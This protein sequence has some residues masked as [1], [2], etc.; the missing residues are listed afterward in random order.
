ML[1]EKTYLHRFTVKAVAKGH[2][3][4]DNDLPVIESYR[5]L[6]LTPAVAVNRHYS[7]L[8][9]LSIA[10]R[11]RLEP[12]IIAACNSFGIDPNTIKNVEADDD[13]RDAKSIICYLAVNEMN[14]RPHTVIKEELGF[15]Y[16]SAVNHHKDRAVGRKDSLAFLEKMNAIASEVGL[17]Q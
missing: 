5:A 1:N 4:N 10:D 3:I 2:S 7:K 13:T 12:L 8:K 6:E 15:K 16:N 17:E 9:L 11:E 14:I